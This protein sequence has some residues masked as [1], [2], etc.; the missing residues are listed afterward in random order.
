MVDKR[1]FFL[2]KVKK[3]TTKDFCKDWATDGFECVEKDQC[4]E[5]GHFSTE[6]SQVITG[7]RISD[8]NFLKKVNIISKFLDIRKLNCRNN[9]NDR[10]V[11]LS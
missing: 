5:D 6:S 8:V 7:P 1:F 9:F 11:E 3:Q 10:S 2:G 4:E